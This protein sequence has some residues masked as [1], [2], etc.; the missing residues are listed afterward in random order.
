MKI[1]KINIFQCNTP[2][3]FSFHSPHL[4]RIQADSIVVELRFNNDISG[5]GE[6]APRPYVT[7]ETNSSVV[8]TIQNHFSKILFHREINS[9]DDVENTINLLE[10]ECHNKKNATFNSAL[11]AID[12]ALLDALGKFQGVPLHNYLGPFTGDKIS[13][14]LSLPFFHNMR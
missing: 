9:L 2:F 14:S 1:I 3:K 8:N 7:G 4:H 11:G 6:S 10:K 13:C 12:I 5:Y